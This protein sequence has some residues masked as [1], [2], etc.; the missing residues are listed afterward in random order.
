MPLLPLPP[1]PSGASLPPIFASEDIC[2]YGLSTQRPTA[3]RN[4]LGRLWYETDTGRISQCQAELGSS[5][6]WTFI[7]SPSSVSA[8]LSGTYTPTLTNEANLNSST[9]Y[10]CQYVRVGDVVT[11]SGKVDVD[12][13]SATILTQLG[14]SLPIASDLANS[15]ECSG[16]ASVPGGVSPNSAAILGNTANNRARMEWNPST[17]YVSAMYFQFMYLVVT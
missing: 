11:V 4:L 12:I 5:P 15:Q 3:N 9:A 1:F 17:A 2:L 16:V 8:L 7:S 13:T 6:S 10:I 14:I